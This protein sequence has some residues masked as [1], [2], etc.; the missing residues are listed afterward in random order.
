MKCV[1]CLGTGYI[2][3]KGHLVSNALGIPLAQCP[4]T[5]KEQT[6]EC[7]STILHA[8]STAA[9]SIHSKTHTSHRCYWL[10]VWNHTGMC[11]HL[12]QWIQIHLAH[13]H[14]TAFICDHWFVTWLVTDKQFCACINIVSC[15]KEYIQNNEEGMTQNVVWWWKLT[16]NEEIIWNNVLIKWNAILIQD[17]KIKHIFWLTPLSSFVLQ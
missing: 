10:S 1:K 15:V 16:F 13:K 12:L 9:I 2:K 4:F 3:L 17:Y 5:H 7:R 11:C 6:T 8:Y 14:G